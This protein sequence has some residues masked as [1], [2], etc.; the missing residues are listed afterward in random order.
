[1]ITIHDVVENRGF[2][3]SPIKIIYHINFGYP[4]LNEGCRIYSS[5]RNVEPR[6]FEAQRGMDRYQIV[7]LPTNDYQEQCFFY[8][9]SAE[10]A[11]V[12]LH[13]ENLGIAAIV[14]YKYSQCPLLCEWKS[15]RAGDYTL[16]LEPASPGIFNHEEETRVLESGESFAYQIEIE[17]T[18]SYEQIHSLIQSSM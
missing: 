14:R 15:M 4:M 1:M 5:C 8:T 16:G 11:F 6:D 9:D 2:V 7:E 3:S 18:D 10:N 17:M 12:M 13:N